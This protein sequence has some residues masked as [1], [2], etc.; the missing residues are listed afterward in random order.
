[1]NAIATY[2][3]ETL[4]VSITDNILTV[5]LNRPHKK[6]A[7]SFQ[8]V[9]ELIAVAG[10]ISKD[11]T[12]R[13]VILNGAEATFCAG[14]DLGDLNHP[15]NQAFAVWELIKPW[16]S[17][18]QRV[19]LVWRDVPVPVIAVL[20]GYCIGAGLQLALACDVRVSHPDCKLSIMEAKWGLV[21]DMGL[22]QSAFGVVREDTLKELAMSA[23]I[24]DASKG[25]ELGLISHCSET[26]LEE[27]QKLAAEF[28]ER[29][30]DAVLASKRIINA[31][32]QQPKTTL[33]KEKVWQL[34]MMLGRNRKLALRKAKQAST[35]FGKRQ[36][37]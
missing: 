37:R 5:T 28:A 25:C 23:R 34:K 31:M 3:Y 14:I 11:K 35:V 16:Q 21:P 15:K 19:C 2:Q 4:Q 33:Y 24:I 32:H 27:A 6:N 17:S 1:M 20:E 12:I 9:N 10:R 26:P 8:V 30:P 22:T 29:S 7:M 18:F 13:A 36:F